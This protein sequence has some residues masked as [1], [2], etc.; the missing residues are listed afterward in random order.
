LKKQFLKENEERKPEKILNE[1]HLVEE[2]KIINNLNNIKVIYYLNKM[3]TKK[4]AF[5]VY[6][7]LHIDTWNKMMFLPVTAKYLFLAGNICTSTNDY[8]IPFMDYC[9]KKWENVFFV[10]GNHEF[11]VKKKNYNELCFDY[12]YKL[13]NRYKNIH[14]LD[15]DFISLNDEINV[16]GST[17]WNIPPFNST[18]EA[19]FSINDY[20]CI[21]YFN[22]T[23]GHTVDLDINYVKEL[24]N[25]SLNKLQKHLNESDKKTIVM[26][27]FPPLRSGTTNPKYLALDRIQNPYYTWRDNTL[28]NFNLK[29]VPIWISGHTH[30]SYDFKK[31][32]TR[33]I[34]NQLGYNYELGETG[35]NENAVF[36]F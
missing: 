26:T 16:Y 32:N 30:W 35:L 27:H 34:S 10:P 17:F 36:E 1:K 4:I 19:K 22:K 7:D 24:A 23:K 29:N 21:T 2:C 11:Y 3:A 5:Q 20:N 25:D 13:N 12:K 28:N 6:S 31:D 14:Y 33:F 15:N 8:F 18:Y 9:S